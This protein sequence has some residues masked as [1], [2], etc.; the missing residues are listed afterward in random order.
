MNRLFLLNFRKGL[1]GDIPISAYA[2][3]PPSPARYL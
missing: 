3:L 1:K 2:R